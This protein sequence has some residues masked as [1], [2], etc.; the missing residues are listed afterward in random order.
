[1]LARGFSGTSIRDILARTD[2]TKGAFFH[3]FRSKEALAQALIERWVERRLEVLHRLSAV[4]DEVAEDPLESL[5]LFC[6]FVEAR[7]Q[8]SGEPFRGGMVA[9]LIYESEQFEADV[10]A[11]LQDALR[12]WTDIYRHKLTDVLAL[13]EPRVPVNAN[14]YAEHIAC[15]LEGAFVMARAYSDVDLIVRQSRLVRCHLEL[16]FGESAPEITA[17]V[18]RAKSAPR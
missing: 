8:E 14:D 1:M 3:H 17:S 12:R 5:L 15:V 11:F 18:D 6:R 10:N 2:L 4:A 7:F 13:R 16:L 9:S